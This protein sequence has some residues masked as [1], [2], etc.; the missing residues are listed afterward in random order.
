MTC[1]DCPCLYIE[2][3]HCEPRIDPDV[4]DIGITGGMSDVAYL[5]KV[6]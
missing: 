1:K 5:K 6:V 3:C 2:G 4:R